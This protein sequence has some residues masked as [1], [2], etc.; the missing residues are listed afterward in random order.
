MMCGVVDQAFAEWMNDTDALLWRIERDPLLRSTITSVWF[1]DA[2]PDRARADAAVERMLANVPRT[3]QRVI[4]DPG[5]VATPRWEDDPFFDPT[6]HYQ[7]IRL[8]GRRVTD[9]DVLRRAQ[10]VAARAFDRDRPLWE[11]EILDG[12]TGKRAAVV[13]KVHHAM[14]DGLGM[15]DLMPYLLDLEAQ[16][17][18]QPDGDADADADET[19]HPLALVPVPGPA[20]PIVQ[21]A[22]TEGRTGVR[23]SKAAVKA[24][25]GFVRD[26]VRTAQD[27]S[28]T[29]ASVVKLV[30]PATTPK[31]PVM[32]GRSLS[33]R[34]DT[35]T[36]PLESMK[37]AAT[38]LGGT[39]NDVFMTALLEGLHR[40]HVRH[41]VDC[42]EVRFQ[43]PVS[44]RGAADAAASN[45]FVPT[46]FMLPL[47]DVD[48]RAR[49]DDA[50][51]RLRDVRAEPALPLVGDVSAIVTRLGRAASVSLLG[52]MMKGVDVIASNV[53]GPP[54]PV[55]FGGARVEHFYGFGPLGG[56]A[57]NMTLFSFDGTV[58]LGV[59]TDAAAVPDRA[60]FVQC[61]Q[62]GFDAV[63]AAA[64]EDDA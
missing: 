11:I 29:A 5:G 64:E 39:L 53:P 10:V 42:P 7:W 62:E 46:R 51:A 48:L 45:H 37:A 28:R 19:P 6:V 12:I 31:S 33:P 21:R 61:I 55:W 3:R 13:M 54:F 63:V 40:Y 56:A 2:V 8:A 43:M 38:A 24:A 32:T 15:V 23:Y 20:R 59:N 26:P 27:T 1:L 18:R 36:L 60:A 35:I 30:L 34:F 16:P 41:G 17:A 22:V 9:A 58:H 50:K 25:V 52:S 49:F 47:A 57:V 4:D 44:V 14:G